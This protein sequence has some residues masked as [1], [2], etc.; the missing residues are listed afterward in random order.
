[1]L[2]I[3]LLGI[4]SV[5]LMQISFEVF[6]IFTFLLEEVRFLV[7]LRHYLYDLASADYSSP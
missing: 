3:E 2:S 7:S 4:I 1:M 5:N 6:V